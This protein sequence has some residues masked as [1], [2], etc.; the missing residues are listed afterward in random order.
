MVPHSSSLDFSGQAT[1]EAWV[2]P[3]SGVSAGTNNATIVT[4][5]DP[6]V[7]TGWALTEEAGHP[8]IGSDSGSFSVAGNTTLQSGT[9]THLAFVADGTTIT[10]YANGTSIALY[11]GGLGGTLLNP[12]P[13]TITANQY[14]VEIG[15]WNPGNAMGV[16]YGAIDVVRIYARARTAAEIC[17]DANRTWSNGTC[18]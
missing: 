14:E 10:A 6:T 17:E 9:W 11:E 3:S 1:I 18:I 16:F 12:R 4:K 7:S 8:N 13:G 2:N 5:F 15:N